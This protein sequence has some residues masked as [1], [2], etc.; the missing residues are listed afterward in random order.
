MYMVVFACAS[1]GMVNCQIMEA[2]KNT[3]NALEAFNRFFDETCVPKI[4][5][6]DKDGA[7]MKCLSEGSVDLLSIDGSLAKGRGIVF[8][9][10]SA[11]GHNAHGRIERKIK[12]VQEVFERSEF[13]RFKLHGLGWQTVAK[14]VEHQVNSIPL[15]YLTH[16]EDNASLLRVLTP[17][18]LKLNAGANRSPDSLFTLPR[19]GKDLFSRVEDA[20]KV[21]YKVFNEDYVPLIAKRHQWHE[22]H[23]NLVEGDII[24]FKLIDSVLGS[25]WLV[26]KVEDVK[27]SKDGKVRRIIVGYKYSSEEGEKTFRVV[28]RPVRECVKLLNI[29]DTTIFEDIERVREE[30]KRIL[31][32]EELSVTSAV[33]SSARAATTSDKNCDLNWI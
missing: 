6:I 9:T 19:T 16:K 22:E 29:D 27:L 12:M 10:C 3:S 20:Y 25:K 32:E 21:F 17:N 13:K 11:Q 2:G 14:N 30:C 26:G 23:E 24:Y 8:E 18:F 15:G 28:E 5:F 4:F 31:G 1:T 7:M 33:S